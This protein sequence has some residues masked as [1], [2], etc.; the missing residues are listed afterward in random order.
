MGGTTA[1]KASKGTAP[2]ITQSALEMT[3]DDVTAAVMTRL[4]DNADFIGA[5]GAVIVVKLA[6]DE[7]LRKPLT[8]AIVVS[9]LGDESF[10]VQLCEHFVT[11]QMPHD[12]LANEDFVAGVGNLI[13]ARVQSDDFPAT[14]KPA[15]DDYLDAN[16]SELVEAAMPETPEKA[17]ARRAEE[18]ER[19]RAEDERADQKV[20]KQREREAAKLAEERAALKATARHQRAALTAV[21]TIADPAAPTDAETA[22]LAAHR[23]PIDLPTVKRGSLLLD[24][25]TQLSID[26]SRAV[27]PSELQP[28]DGNSLLLKAPAISI[29]AGMPEAFAIEAVMLVLECEQGHRVL[30]CPMQSRL[31]VGGGATAELGADS[32]LFRPI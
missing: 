15:I 17:A 26:F 6:G 18:A 24:D 28:M 19:A 2:E 32:L 21:P 29:G 20:A 23:S 13:T 22:A 3:P 5:L 14:I 10:K 8:D 12:I 25:G 7:D 31:L 16:L 9:L 1:G 11:S 4:L 27:A 30:H